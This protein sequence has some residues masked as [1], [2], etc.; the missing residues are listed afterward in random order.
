MCNGNQSAHQLTN[1]G[2]NNNNR[3]NSI[4]IYNNNN[5]YENQLDN[6]TSLKINSCKVTHIQP[7]NFQGQNL[8]TQQTFPENYSKS[9]NSTQMFRQS[10]SIFP[11]NSGGQNSTTGQHSYCADPN[12][13]QLSNLLQTVKNLAQNI[14]NPKHNIAQQ[15]N[16]LGNTI[17]KQT[18][19]QRTPQ[20]IIEASRNPTPKLANLREN[21]PPQE[22]DQISLRIPG[23]LEHPGSKIPES[24]PNDS[25]KKTLNLVKIMGKQSSLKKNPPKNLSPRLSQPTVVNVI[26]RGLSDIK[27]PDQTMDE[28]N[29][30]KNLSPRL[31]QP[32][33]VNVISHGLSDI[34]LPDPIIV[35][36]NSMIN[37]CKVLPSFL[38]DTC[39]KGHERELADSR[40]NLNPAL[41]LSQE[42]CSVLELIQEDIPPPSTQLIQDTP[43]PSTQCNRQVI[44]L[45]ALQLS[46]DDCSDLE[47]IQEDTAPSSQ[48]KMQVLDLTDE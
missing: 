41:K 26:S 19:M 38:H 30:P 17:H 25:T 34:K 6:Y 20:S 21:P 39:T 33:A 29:P 23:N 46:Q 12:K 10:G 22:I 7:Q 1:N 16:S 36:Q 47:L 3:F 9:Q 43:P 35:R 11:Q 27:L 4:E 32:T 14:S 5:N 15:Q 40:L 37:S 18:I 13:A 28:K 2:N 8:S 42:D 24:V 44:D 48:C 31:P 45:T